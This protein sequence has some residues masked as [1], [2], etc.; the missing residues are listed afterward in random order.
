V[1]LRLAPIMTCALAAIALPALRAHAQLLLRGPDAPPGAAVSSLDER[2]VYVVDPAGS[3]HLISWDRVLRIEGPSAEEAAPYMQ[4]AEDAWRAR[5]RLQRADA[6]G[7]E[8]LFEDLFAQTRA[9]RGPTRA[10]IAEGLMRCRLRRGAQIG[11][12]DPWLALIESRASALAGIE[13]YAP[14]WAQE[15][16]LGEVLDPATGLA[17]ALPPMWLDWPAVR[18]FAAGGGDI[19]AEPAPPTGEQASTLRALYT[20]A[21]RFEAGLDA[22]LPPAVTPTATTDPGVRLVRDIVA[23]RIAAP[24][25]RVAARTRLRSRL[26]ADIEPWLDAW[27]RVAIGRSLLRE[28]DQGSRLLGVAELLAAPALHAATHPYLAGLALAEAARALSALNR[29]E[30]SAALRQELADRFPSHP[31]LTVVRAPAPPPSAAPDPR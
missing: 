11:A 23:A 8:A 31:A 20:A 15:A 2:G 29:H 12:I 9:W 4:L 1:I 5:R 26:G 22:P 6:V 19:D 17:P 7:A 18:Q 13:P 28:P 10:V 21:A 27:L 14:A 24:Q 30:Q 16:G 25:E 3:L